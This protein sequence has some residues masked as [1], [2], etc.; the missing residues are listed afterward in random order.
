VRKY[1]RRDVN[2]IRRR[3]DQP[4]ARSRAPPPSTA[5]TPP[6][7]KRPTTRA[8]QISGDDTYAAIADV[9]AFVAEEIGTQADVE[10]VPS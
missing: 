4:A 7:S 10:A 5:R 1:F 3:G 9:E 2:V 6:R 8:V